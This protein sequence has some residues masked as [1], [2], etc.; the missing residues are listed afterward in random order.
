MAEAAEG[1]LVV[2]PQNKGEE[3]W[4]EEGAGSGCARLPRQ[5]GHEPADHPRPA[6]DRSELSLESSSPQADWPSSGTQHKQSGL[7]LFRA[8]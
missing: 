7:S 1:Q 5:A 8:E 2:T 6:E 3:S 4:Q